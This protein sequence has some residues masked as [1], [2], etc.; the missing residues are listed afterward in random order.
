MSF[1]KKRQ[2]KRSKYLLAALATSVFCYINTGYAAEMQAEETFMLDEVVVTATRSEKTVLNTAASVDVVT[3]QDIEKMSVN[4]VNEVLARIPGIYSSRLKG[5]ANDSPGVLMRGF[6][7]QTQILVMVDGQPLNDANAGTVQWS[8]IPLNSVEKVEVV[9]GVAS[10]LYGSS[11][12][13]GVINIVTKDPSQIT[14]NVSVGYGSDNT[15]IERIDFGNKLNDQ[16]SF[17]ISYEGRKTDGYVNKFVNVT[18]TKTKPSG[19]LTS[20]GEISGLK[21]TVNNLGEQVYQ[22]GN[23]GRNRFEEDNFHGKFVYQLDDEKKVSFGITHHKGEYSYDYSIYNN[24]LRKNNEV[25]TGNINLGDGYLKVSPSSFYNGGGGET[26]NM[27]TL[28][29][30]DSANQWKVNFGLLDTRES[31]SGGKN[32]VTKAGDISDS[33][34]KRYNI[35][36]QKQF[37]LTDKDTLIAGAQY[38]KDWIHK[39]TNDVN[40]GILTKQSEGNAESTGL[41]VQNEHIINDRFS[42]L[43]SLRYDEWKV[44]DSWM[45]LDKD[46]SKT[47]YYGD[48]SDSAVSPKVALQ[49]KI[50][51]AE[52]SYISW[53]KAFAAPSLQ[54]MFSGAASSSSYTEANPDLEPQK[55]STVEVGWKKKFNDKTTL[56]VAYFHNDISNL[57]YTRKSGLGNITYTVN[58]TT[59]TKP[60]QRVENAGSAT[61]DGIE[62]ELEHR[63][64]QKWSGFLN[65]VYQNSK[66]DECT[67]NDKA[68]GCQLA[69]VPKQI[70][71]IGIDYKSGRWNGELLGSYQSKMYGQDDNSDTAENVFGAYDGYFIANLNVKYQMN[72][73]SSIEFGI[74]NLFDKKYY[75]YNLSPER[76]YMVRVN[77]SF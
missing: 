42:L 22:V 32:P 55:V 31:W 67:T 7:N 72:E 56:G 14:N 69:Y 54:K 60:I 59:Y 70:F 11:A 28:A 2:T 45:Q 58:G 17:A 74:N 61:T 27:Y 10:S 75:S 44:K 24:D 65:Y 38:T 5:I 33:P 16:F 3:A 47:K 8:D 12:M 25:F 34:N 18:P 48:R 73:N 63:F 29:Y 77:Y 76:N 20:V 51:D 40:T 41:Y 49:Y 43:T 1:W 4:T 52:S 68:I 13:G 50:N 64:S 6:G 23:V 21:E 46:A 71:N 53:G 36:I 39:R 30:E 62:L 37:A 35:N 66:I 19:T 57:L 9:K 15:R 26:Q